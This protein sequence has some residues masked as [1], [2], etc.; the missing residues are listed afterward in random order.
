MREAKR[1]LDRHLTDAPDCEQLA[2]AV[3]VSVS[4]LARLFSEVT[5]NT[6]HSYLIE[7]E[8]GTRGASA[9]RTEECEPGGRAVRILQHEPFFRLL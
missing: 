3:G 4:R 6:I 9:D 8:T 2:R 1:I 5:G 7:R